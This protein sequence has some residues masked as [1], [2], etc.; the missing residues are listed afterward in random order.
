MGSRAA[1]GEVNVFSKNSYV[2]ASRKRREREEDMDSSECVSAPPELKRTDT[3]FEPVSQVEGGGFESSAGICSSDE[4][5][6]S[7]CPCCAKC[8]EE[9]VVAAQALTR[10]MNVLFGVDKK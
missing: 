1:A 7:R 2:G 4:E 10:A 3:Y 8:L 5:S 6:C 9:V